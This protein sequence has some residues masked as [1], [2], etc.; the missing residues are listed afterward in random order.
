MR[1]VPGSVAIQR[2]NLNS[3]GGFEVWIARCGLALMIFNVF[4]MENEWITGVSNQQ[5]PNWIWFIVE[6]VFVTDK[7]RVSFYS[8]SVHLRFFLFSADVK[9]THEGK[10]WKWKIDSRIRVT[11]TSLILPFIAWNHMS[12]E[13]MALLFGRLECWG[14]LFFQQAFT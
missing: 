2:Q 9:A 12:G 10:F 6:S 5:I 13:S 4:V 1:T 3:E 11:I 7:M 14:R 8:I